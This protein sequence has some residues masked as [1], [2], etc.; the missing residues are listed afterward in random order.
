MK[1]MVKPEATVNFDE[2]NVC[3]SS[4]TCDMSQIQATS[5]SR[6][7]CCCNGG[8]A[9]GSEDACTKCP[10]NF[11]KAMVKPEATVNFDEDNV[12]YSS[13]TCDMSQIQATST[14]RSDCCCNG[15][16]ACGSEDACTK[17]P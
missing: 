4:N 10:T 13:N 16:G 11:M 3:Y 6:S 17:C 14:S 1:A 12:C 5:T 7:D 15:G 8:G 9:W 2:D